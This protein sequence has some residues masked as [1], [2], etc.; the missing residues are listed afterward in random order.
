M[1][2]KDKMQFSIKKYLVIALA[3]TLYGVGISLF[4]DPNNLAPG[5]FTGLSVIINRLMAT[6]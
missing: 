6:A 2:M 4:V 3:C 5:G 1:K